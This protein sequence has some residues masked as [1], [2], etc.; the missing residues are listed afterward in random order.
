MFQ[1]NQDSLATI[2]LCSDLGLNADMKK[3]YKPYTTSQW[4]K[5][6]EKIVNSSIQKPSNLLNI[7][8]E[9]LKEELF[10]KEDESNR[11][12]FLLK[13]GGNIAIEI[14][15]LE[16]SGIYITTRA[17][18]NYPYRLKKILKNYSPPIIY[19]SGNLDLTNKKSI[20]IVGSRDV[21]SEGTLFTKK[22]VSKCAKEGYVIVSGGAKG[23]DTIAENTS[24]EENGYAI[25]IV[26]NNL[27]KKIKEKSVRNSILEGR[28]LALSIA[29]PNA[30]FTVYAA[31]DRNKYIYGL[32]QWAVVVSSSDSKGGTWTGAVDNLKKKWVPL[33]VRDGEKIPTGN[34]KLIELGGNPISLD[35]IED[36][37]VSFREFFENNIENSHRHEKAQQIDIYSL[38]KKSKEEVTQVMEDSNNESLDVYDLV[39][40]NI[41][42]A[43]VEPKNQKELSE[44]LNVNSKQISTWLKRA[45]EDNEILKLTNPARY[46]L[47]GD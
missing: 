25:S 30:N 36:S 38:Y 32:S 26:P 20:A 3:I 17:E 11:I 29:N 21:D 6:V 28:L 22:F 31:M 1:L 47:K 19:Y 10:L 9:E 7:E 46:T 15:R 45:L 40:P 5:L 18:K 2:L 23:V 8:K 34:K 39:L 44:I 43:L 41:K 27:N 4:N 35:I 42:K 13:R 33:Y 24:I 16:S 14:E 37:N 12:D